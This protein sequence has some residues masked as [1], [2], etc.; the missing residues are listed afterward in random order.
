MPALLVMEAA[1]FTGGHPA[2]VFAQYP[3]AVGSRN[4]EDTEEELVRLSRI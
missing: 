2:E 4:N 1:G 3:A